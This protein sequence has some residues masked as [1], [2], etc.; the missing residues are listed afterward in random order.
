MYML[1]MHFANASPRSH[2][3]GQRGQESL[4]YALYLDRDRMQWKID[5]KA[6]AQRVPKFY[7]VNINIGG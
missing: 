2:V 7:A 3:E 1:D 4:P 5:A 6:N